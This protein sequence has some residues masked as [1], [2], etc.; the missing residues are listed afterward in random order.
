M[1]LYLLI[2]FLFFVPHLVHLQQY[3]FNSQSNWSLNK[4]E[5]QLGL[6]ATQFSGDL[7]GGPGDGKD[8]SLKDVDL[9]ATRFAGWLGYRQRFHRHFAT[10]SSLCVFQLKGNDRWSDAI[11]RFERNSHFRAFCI[12]A[13]QRFEFIFAATET[14][15]P[16]FNFPG[17]YSSKKNR[18]EQYYLFGGVGLLYFNSR[19]RYI[20]GS[21]VALRPLKTEG[22]SKMYSPVTLTIPFGV[23]FRIGLDRTWRIGLELAY[24][25]TF[26]D[27]IDDVSTYF[28]DPTKLGS[29]EAVYFSNPTTSTNTAYMVGKKRG[30]PDHKDAYYHINF[31]VTRNLTFKDFG[32][33]RQQYNLKSAGKFKV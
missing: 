18:N 9:Q 15:S 26:S 29:P 21:M 11:S 10:T 17:N 31:I 2:I 19:A 4:K 32:K 6:G 3:N 20:D 1:K 23:G 5:L 25:K 22:Q 27:Y 13:Q 30:D 7:G 8:Y 33:E 12:E 24:V 28:A 14:Y 16:I